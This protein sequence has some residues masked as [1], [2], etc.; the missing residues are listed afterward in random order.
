MLSTKKIIII[1]L[2]VIAVIGAGFLVWMNIGDIRYRILDIKTEAVKQKVLEEEE[3]RDEADVIID[4]EA[5]EEPP[6]PI[7]QSGVSIPVEVYSYQG[8]VMDKAENSLKVKISALDN[9]IEAD[10]ILEVRLDQKT[11]ITKIVISSPEPG[12]KPQ[13]KMETIGADEI[14]IGD[15]ITITSSQNIAGKTAFRAQS[16]RVVE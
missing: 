16:I 6:V 1:I 12:K 9:Y 7:N 5:E 2:I 15:R 10:Q 11:R 8:Q 14:N 3:I 4:K 13:A